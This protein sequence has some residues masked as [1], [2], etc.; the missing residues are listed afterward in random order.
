[1]ALTLQTIAI[2]LVS[3]CFQV[4]GA[5]MLPASKGFTSVGPSLVCVGSFAIALWLLARLIATGAELSILIPF[6]STLTPL[7][8][9]AVGVLVYGESINAMKGILLVIA[10]GLVVVAAR[11]G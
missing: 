3:V 11:V 1:M 8:S 2:F 10:C 5:A 4:L 7:A 6:S 9:V